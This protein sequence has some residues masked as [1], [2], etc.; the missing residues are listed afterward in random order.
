MGIGAGAVTAMVA[1]MKENFR[2]RSQRKAFENREATTRKRRKLVFPEG[3]PEE[4]EAFHKMMA[5]YH[6]REKTGKTLAVI[7]SVL[8]TAGLIAGVTWVMVS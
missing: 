3:T 1:T 6:R 4:K 2:I 7:F 5:R 8:F